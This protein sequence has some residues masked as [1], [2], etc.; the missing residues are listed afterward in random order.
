MKIRNVTRPKDMDDI[1][2]NVIRDQDGKKPKDLKQKHKD[3]KK[4]VLGELF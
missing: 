2:T 3:I 4:E 1:M